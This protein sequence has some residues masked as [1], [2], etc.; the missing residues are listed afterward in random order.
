MTRR[1]FGALLGAG[2]KL[3]SGASQQRT[4]S[5]EPSSIR[6]AAVQMTPKLA[7]V[8]ANLAKAERLVRLAFK[9]GARW[10]I[11]PEFFT[12]AMAFHKDM[13][14]AI[15]DVNGSPAQLLRKLAREG[16]GFVGGSFLAWRDGE[17][18]N[19]FVLAL[20]DGRTLRHD[21]D[22]P[23]MLENCYY[24]G[25]SDDGVLSTPEGDV[26]AAVCYEFVRSKTASRLKDKVSMVIGGSC[27]WGMPDSA[28]A[29]H[30]GHKWLLDE[31]RAT[32]A[33]FARLLGVPVIHASHAGHFVGLDWPGK[34]VRFSSSYLGETQI[35]TGRGEILARL[36]RE[37]GE[38][39]ITA[40]VTLGQA[41]GSERPPIPARF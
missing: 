18:Y 23:T 35:V 26:G 4:G 22:Y 17:V 24:I 31:L 28:P 2:P 14:N 3:A 38:D 36:T 5:D 19:S 33:R 30:P 11:L 32:P 8:E 16:N 34:P 20:P 41:L 25:G 1:R 9:R 12:S 21:K 15:R 7:N 29:D 13:A 39:I 6:V 37:Q 10:V 40:D 27:W